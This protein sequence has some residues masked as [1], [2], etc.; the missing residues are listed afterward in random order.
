MTC[1]RCRC[2]GCCDD[3]VLFRCPYK[4]FRGPGI[5]IISTDFRINY[6]RDEIISGPVVFY[7]AQGCETPRGPG[8][9]SGS[10]RKNKIKKKIQKYKQKRRNKRS[11]IKYAYI[12][13][14][15]VAGEGTA[16]RRFL[17]GDGGGS[18]SSSGEREKKRIPVDDV[19]SGFYSTTK[20]LKFMRFAI[21]LPPPRRIRRAFFFHF[22]FVQRSTHKSHKRTRERAR[23]YI[24]LYIIRI[25]EMNFKNNCIYA[26][27]T[28][29]DFIRRRSPFREPN[30]FFP[31][32]FV[33]PKNP[34]NYYII[35]C[36]YAHTR[37]FETN[38]YIRGRS[39]DTHFPIHQ[40]PE[41]FNF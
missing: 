2:R 10:K 36:I 16:R 7:V 6:F 32:D 4:H 30:D 22:F 23:L 1:F 14:K 17:G 39:Q 27:A 15:G 11:I 33:A 20:A 12:V 8:L 38:A 24:F 41:F 34:K 13:G 19:W 3:D 18:S 9:G 26:A 40:R 29:F 28:L 25:R 35:V 21:T 37:L 31:C 5:P